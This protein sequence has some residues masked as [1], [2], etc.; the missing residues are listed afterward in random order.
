MIGRRARPGFSDKRSKLSPRER[1]RAATVDDPRTVRGSPTPPGSRPARRS[2][3]AARVG[4]QAVAVGAVTVDR[5]RP[6]PRSRDPRRHGDTPRPGDPVR[7]GHRHREGHPGWRR[8]GVRPRRHRGHAS[9]G[10]HAQVFGDATVTGGAVIGGHAWIHG[11]ARVTGEA[12]VH[13]RSQIGG[14]RPDLRDRGHRRAVADRWGRRHRRRRRDLHRER[15]TRPIDCP[16]VKRSPSIDA[17][18]A[19]SGSAEANLYM[20]H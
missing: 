19:P 3:A 16:G 18:T 6:A 13:G 20:A 12:W 17:R 10:G 1:V 4:G 8:L 5:R 2:P 9:I 7:L 11:S 15:L 14:Q